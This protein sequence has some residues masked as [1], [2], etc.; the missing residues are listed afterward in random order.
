M[1]AKSTKQTTRKTTKAPRVAAKKKT[2]PSIV[3]NLEKQSNNYNDSLRFGESYTSLVLG[4]IVV[5]IATVLLLSFIYN[6]NINN[7]NPQITTL[8]QN[9][10]A[11][12]PTGVPS[13]G[14]NKDVR[15][16]PLTKPVKQVRQGQTYTVTA[17]DDLWSIAEKVYNDG[18]KWTEIAKANKLSNPSMIYR[19][20][21]LRIPE[22]KNVAVQQ[23]DKI[24]NDTSVQKSDKITGNSYTIQRGDTLWSIA[25]R[26][27]GDG[28]RYTDIAKVNKLDNNPR[29]IH[30]DNVLTLPRK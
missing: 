17:G 6:R 2:T 23:S 1:A 4:I 13:T 3:E 18:Y 26:A 20:D 10:G 19:G 21:K 24:R 15:E 5:I 28:F 29:L 30:A 9:N 12:G 25:E 7:M 27:Y 11:Y 14:D 8:T 22:I 16:M